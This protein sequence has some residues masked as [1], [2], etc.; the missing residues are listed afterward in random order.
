MGKDQKVFKIIDKHASYPTDR[1]VRATEAI[2]ST[3]VIR[4]A[5]KTDI[6]YCKATWSSQVSSLYDN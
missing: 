4:R 5:N 3:Y 2:I 6:R 1:S